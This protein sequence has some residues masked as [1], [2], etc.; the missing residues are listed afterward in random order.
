[1]LIDTKTKTHIYF[2]RAQSPD[3][4]ISLFC[5]VLMRLVLTMCTFFV[6]RYINI[7]IDTLPKHTT[8]VQLNNIVSTLFQPHIYKSFIGILCFDNDISLTINLNSNV[9]IL[10]I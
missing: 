10:L 7:R 2:L 8:Y 6:L 5:D 3:I 1:M 9:S 4:Q